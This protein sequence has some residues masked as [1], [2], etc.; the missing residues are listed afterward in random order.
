M[1]SLYVIESSISILY[2]ETVWTIIQF[3]DTIVLSTIIFKSSMPLYIF[4][5]Y[6]YEL[7]LFSVSNIKKFGN[8]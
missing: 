2:S 5:I 3:I 4:Q 7:I 8:Y 6:Y 1:K